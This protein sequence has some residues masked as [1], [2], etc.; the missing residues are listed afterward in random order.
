MSEEQKRQWA[1]I[2]W[3]V[4][5]CGGSSLILSRISEMSDDEFDEILDMKISFTEQPKPKLNW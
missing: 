1:V 3:Y 5:H 4:Q 2:A